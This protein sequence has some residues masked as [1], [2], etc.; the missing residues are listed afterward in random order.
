MHLI[1]CRSSLCIE[2]CVAVSSLDFREIVHPSDVGK[3]ERL[4]RAAVSGFC[5]L[6]RPARADTVQIDA[7][8]L[9]LY[10]K[11]GVDALRYV[12]AALSEC[13]VAPPGLL[14]RLVNEPVDISAPLLIRSPALSDVALIDLIGRHG[15]GHAR[16]IA[17]RPAL[18]TAIAHLIRALEGAV[19]AS[20]EAGGHGEAGGTRHGEAAEAVR[21]R[22][23]DIMRRSAA[24][25]EQPLPAGDPLGFAK[26]REAAL[27]GSPEAFSITLA[28][29][30]R[31]SA[32]ALAEILEGSG[33]S[34]LLVAL[35][36]LDLAEE[37]AFLIAAAVTPRQFSQPE[38]IRL[39]LERYRML[40]RQTALDRISGWKVEIV[41]TW[42][43][44]NV[45]AG[46]DR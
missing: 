2:C 33:L 20:I 14:E 13:R 45:G 42:I 35:R 19:S 17:R 34:S 41:S 23:R 7:L 27:S 15:L 18:S 31:L 39:F 26:L 46:S 12:A 11:V 8:A 29:M 43:R 21:G 6:T 9:P 28:D 3:P 5:A 1:P 30:L 10:P 22:L 40:D 4:F 36:T 37:Q 32:P 24:G 25:F 16:A 44:R 38:G